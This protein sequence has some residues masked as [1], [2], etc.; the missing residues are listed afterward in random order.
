MNTL[1]DFVAILFFMLFLIAGVSFL[2]CVAESGSAQSWINEHMG[3]EDTARG[4]K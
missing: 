1:S 2:D 3:L 4:C